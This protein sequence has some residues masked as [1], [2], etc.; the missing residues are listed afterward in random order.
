MKDSATQTARSIQIQTSFRQSESSNTS[1]DS[2]AFPTIKFIE[3]QKTPP[4]AKS[5]K[6]FVD[7]EKPV[8]KKMTVGE[9]I[10]KKLATSSEDESAK[11][12]KKVK[13]QLKPKKSD[14]VKTKELQ[15]KAENEFTK[16]PK[17]SETSKKETKIDDIFG[18]FDKSIHM[19]DLEDE[20]ESLDP[21]NVGVEKIDISSTSSISNPMAP[22]SETDISSENKAKILKTKT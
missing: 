12:I 7:L 4:K 14:T 19:P 9:L 15:K 16:T 10:D 1:L 21:L 6:S 20:S 17:H 2:V 5:T 8:S 13:I 18:Y 22:V 3:K 11:S